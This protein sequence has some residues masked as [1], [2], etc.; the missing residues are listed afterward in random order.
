QPVATVSIPLRSI[1]VLFPD[2]EGDNV[3]ADSATK[4][5]PPAGGDGGGGGQGGGGS[6]DKPSFFCGPCPFGVGGGGGGGVR[7]GAGEVG[8]PGQVQ[9]RRY[10]LQTLAGPLTNRTM[11]NGFVVLSLTLVPSGNDLLGEQDPEDSEDVKVPPPPPPKP[12][13]NRIL[14]VPINCGYQRLRKALLWNDSKLQDAF[15][16]LLNY[17]DITRSQ[18]LDLGGEAG[19]QHNLTGCTRDRTFV[20]PKSAMVAS[21]TTEAHDVILADGKTNPG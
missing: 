15:S 5:T 14:D 12:L 4:T 7:G 11:D 21:T 1:P 17:S 3:S 18:W 13:E 16:D 8:S 10:R 19:H 9:A 20:I 6:G 2:G